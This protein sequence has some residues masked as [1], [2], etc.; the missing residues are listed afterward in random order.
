M[1][2]KEIHVKLDVTPSERQRIEQFL[3]KDNDLDPRDRL[4]LSLHALFAARAEET[5]YAKAEF[6]TLRPELQVLAKPLQYA[7]NQ[8]WD[9]YFTRMKSNFNQ[10]L[11]TYK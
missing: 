3:D 7:L 4:M 10:I 9:K 11:D 2:V 6:E 5:E 1:K 8:S